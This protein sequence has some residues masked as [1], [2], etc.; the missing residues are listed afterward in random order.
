MQSAKAIRFGA[1]RTIPEAVWQSLLLMIPVAI[2]DWL[3]GEFTVFFLY[4]VP[5][6]FAVWQCNRK[7]G[8]II[9]L[10]SITSWSIID[11]FHGVSYSH[12][13]YFLSA[14]L[15]RLA[16]FL[17]FVLL[18]AELKTELDKRK[19]AIDDLA[20]SEAKLRNLTAHLQDVR[21]DEKAAVARELHDE[22][23]STLT[24]LKM[25]VQMLAKK[26]DDDA[27]LAKISRMGETIDAAALITR[28]VISQLRP[29][30]LD[31]LGLFPAIAWQC[32][33][34]EEQHAIPTR[35]E[36]GLDDMRLDERRSLA[37]FRI[38]QESLT[39][40]AR[41]AH[42][43]SVIVTASQLNGDLVVTISDDGY[44]ITS[45]RLSDPTSHGVSGMTER[46]LSLRGS[47]KIDGRAD[48][49]TMVS[50]RIPLSD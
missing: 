12:P 45:D 19:R 13:V 29:T 26:I 18:L 41:H 27:A 38:V 21:E 23:G 40:V 30:I 10:L 49:G 5:I 44:G 47:L 9:S 36:C 50:L 25:D 15:G 14:S 31:H 37:V 34:F 11:Y 6:A 32:N 42:A 7:T 24:A 22:L 43:S 46:A 3:A 16:V 20:L 17:V 1:P 4:L 33:E 39:N 48:Q 2:A 28:R 35:W 8:I